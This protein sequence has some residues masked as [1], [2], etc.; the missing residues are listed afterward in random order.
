L[1][2][3]HHEIAKRT[4]KQVQHDS[5]AAP[6]RPQQPAESGQNDFDEPTVLRRDNPEAWKTKGLELHDKGRYQKAIEAYE[7]SLTL[8]PDDPE[9]WYHKGLAL[10]KLKRR[11]EAVR[12]LRRAWRAWGQ[13][14]HKR[15]LV[16]KALGELGHDPEKREEG[17]ANALKQKVALDQGHGRGVSRSSSKPDFLPGRP[18]PE[19]DR[20]QNLPGWW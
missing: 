9:V 14:P 1:S 7:Q 12:W 4:K 15:A 13:L 20:A 19:L 16:T 6:Q 18:N 3:V 11:D 17:Q 10:S 5:K 8:K 2:Q